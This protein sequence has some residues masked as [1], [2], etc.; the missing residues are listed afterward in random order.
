MFPQAPHGNA[1]LTF[2][3]PH[4]MPVYL[5]TIHTYGSC[6]ED[7]PKGY[8]QRGEGLKPSSPR[9]ARWRDEHQKHP[10][11]V[12]GESQQLILAKACRTGCGRA[13]LR[14]HAVATAPTH[15]HLLAS[16]PSPRCTCPPVASDRPHG[17]R[18]CHRACPARR[19]MD[20]F[21]AKL[22]R[23]LGARLAEGAGT[24]GLPY[25][26]RGWNLQR[27]IEREHFDHLVREYLPRHVEQNGAYWDEAWFRGGR[28]EPRI[29]MRG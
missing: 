5:L 19:R 20:G 9:L 10:S 25:L 14:P 18:T 24:R 6:Q 7:H 8:V 1:G 26:S 2:C 16:F 11:V 28:E 4:P 23:N 27:V 22:K 3:Y 17:E 13:E 15:V 21:A 12:L 29:D